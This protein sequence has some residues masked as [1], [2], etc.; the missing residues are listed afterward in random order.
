MLNIFGMRLMVSNIQD[1]DDQFA[2]LVH[3]N[4]AKAPTLVRIYAIK[5][6]IY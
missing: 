2:Q 1:E 4:S 3:I 5:D 6:L